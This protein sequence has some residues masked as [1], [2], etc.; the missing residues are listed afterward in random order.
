M[1]G[2]GLTSLTGR[3]WRAV[4]RGH[5]AAVLEGTIRAGRYNRPGQRTLYMSGSRAGV[6][7]AMAR[8]GAAPRTVARLSVDAERLI[9][10]RDPAAC[11]VL[12]I[13]ASRV[14]EDWIAALDRGDEPASWRASDRARAIGAQGLI[15]G[16]RR[17]PD[18][19]HLV[20]F[21]WNNERGARVKFEGPS[22]E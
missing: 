14:K 15:D 2:G 22:R 9:D 21:A 18:A 11:N 17:L 12:G 8:Y 16:S 6:A 7:A 4:P 3:C 10:L 19:W 1:A 13:D 20:L 5:G